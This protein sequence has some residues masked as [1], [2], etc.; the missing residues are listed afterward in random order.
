MQL[1]AVLQIKCIAAAANIP[2]CHSQDPDAPKLSQGKTPAKLVV[3]KVIPYPAAGSVNTIT[4][5][6][7]GGQTANLTGYR[8]TDS[9][10]RP[11]AAANNFVFGADTDCTGGNI[12]IVP[13]GSLTLRPKNDSNPCGFSFGVAFRYSRIVCTQCGRG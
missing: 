1:K 9:D 8:L 12:T 5:R 7:I 3:E 10:T 13:T 2:E 4:I 6:N 11:V